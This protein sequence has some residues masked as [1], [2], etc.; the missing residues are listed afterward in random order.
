[1]KITEFSEHN[2]LCLPKHA[3]ITIVA[4]CRECDWLATNGGAWHKAFC[5][6]PKIKASRPYADTSEHSSRVPD[7]NIVPD[8]CP[9]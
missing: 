4:S 5:G 6:N 1:M 7:I 9:L 3:R 2:T 8:W